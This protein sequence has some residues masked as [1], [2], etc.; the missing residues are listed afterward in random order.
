MNT[1]PETGFIRLRQIIGDKTT[2]AIIP[3]SRSSWYLGQKQGRFP[4]AISLGARTKVYS[5]ESIRAL[6]KEATGH[7]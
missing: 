5:V 1:L 3:I 6:I 4:A 2:P 7:E